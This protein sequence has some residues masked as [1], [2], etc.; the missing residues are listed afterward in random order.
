MSV[1]L[2]RLLLTHSLHY[3]F[4]LIPPFFLKSFC[5]MSVNTKYSSFLPLPLSLQSLNVKPAPF[6]PWHLHVSLCLPCIKKLFV[7]YSPLFSLHS[8]TSYLLSFLFS[9]FSFPSCISASFSFS[10]S[11][12]RVLHINHTIL[13]QSERYCRLS[14]SKEREREKIEGRKN[15]NSG[16]TDGERAPSERNWNGECE[17]ERWVYKQRRGRMR[18]REMRRGFRT[19]GGGEEEM[20]YFFFCSTASGLQVSWLKNTEPQLRSCVRIS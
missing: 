9:L 20:Q 14:I 3:N 16:G 10:R 5:I 12:L 2:T 18:K 6:T 15:I 8:S 17:E 19:E 11:R 1:I 13:I 4:F 7:A